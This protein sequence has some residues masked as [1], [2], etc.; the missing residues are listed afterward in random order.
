MKY[1]TL[2]TILFSFSPIYAQQENWIKK[3]QHNSRIQYS[4]IDQIKTSKWT[5]HIERYKW[6]EKNSID[7]AGYI[8]PQNTKIKNYLARAN[9]RTD[10]ALGDWI[11]VGLE[12]WTNG[13]SGYNPGNGRVNAITVDP[14]NSNIIYACAASGG[15]WKSIDG[16]SSWNTNTDHFPVLGTSDL[17]IDPNNSNNLYLGTG[18]RDY[19]NTYGVGIYKSTDAGTSWQES[20]LFNDYDSEA[21]VINAIEISPVES[22]IIFA[23]SKDGLYKSIDFGETWHT[24]IENRNIMEIKINP[25]N[26]NTIFAVSSNNFYRSH[27][28]GEHFEIITTGI[29]GTCSRIAMDITPADTSYIYLIISEDA[30]AFKGVYRSTDGGTSFTKQIG[31]ESINL[32]GYNQDG[33]D[34]GTQAWYDLA[35]AVSKTDKNKVYT[36][37]I[38]VWESTNGGTSWLPTT[39]WTYNEDGRYSHADIHSLDFYGNTLYCSSDGGAFKKPDNSNWENISTG[40]NISQIFNFSNSLDGTIISIGCQDNGSNVSTN[41]NWKHV[42][43]ADGMAT[44]IDKNNPN[45]IYL[46]LQKGNYRKSTT[47]GDNSQAI[48]SP[49]DYD[50]TGNWH[51][52]I[53][54]CRSQ[55]N[56]LVIGAQ[57]VFK[58]INSGDTWAKISDFADDEKI[59]TIAIAP[60]NPDYIYA[61]KDSHAYYTHNGGTSWAEIGTIGFEDIVDIAISN[62]D[63]LNVYFLK[64]S[65]YTKVFHSTDGAQTF[66]TVNTNIFQTSSSTI[67]LENNA[68]NGIYIGSEFEIFYSNDNINAWTSYSNQLPRVKITD[69]EVINLK[70]RAAT[71]G[72]GVWETDLYDESVNIKNST[73]YNNF[74]IYPNPAVNSLVLD[75]KDLVIE[76]ILIF[77]TSGILVQEYSVN[78]RNIDISYLVSGIYFIRI[79][80]KNNGQ[81]IKQFIKQ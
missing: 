31:L 12:S 32:F 43:G 75:I 65:S 39:Q 50:E 20:G 33:S 36:G 73:A 46:S 4:E 9:K 21:M 63:P 56:T 19:L 5:K 13:D 25:I 57:N 23:G 72:R 26:P 79:Q 37:G 68:E 6:S 76:S 29:E 59:N 55:T 24:V 30:Q 48:F 42:M 58:T 10:Q 64:S 47:G 14:N 11:P 74:N 22:N 2:L 51:T 62:S 8:I 77:N 35:I 44:I 66:S 18:D 81:I 16:G 70:V 27:D 67:C 17:A 38:N 28:G 60:S 15:V 34:D 45:I 78:I 54:M 61:T 53:D 69:L 3:I 52:P 80:T 1:F 40:L 49:S 41:N 71:Y 7:E